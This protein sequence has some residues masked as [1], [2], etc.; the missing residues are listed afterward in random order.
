MCCRNGRQ[1]RHHQPLVLT[2]GQFA[3]KKYQERHQQQG[4][5]SG[6]ME[7]GL[8]RRSS[9]P[10][11]ILGRDAN[12]EILEK[13]GIAPPSYD[14]V[15]GGQLPKSSYDEKRAT[16]SSDNGDSDD[17]SSLLSAEEDKESA[18]IIAAS[19]TFVK[20]WR[21]NRGLVLEEPGPE[22]EAGL[23]RWQQRR[24]E[25]AVRKAERAARRAD[26][27]AMGC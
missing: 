21:A 24:A 9:P 1:R 19:E 20:D 4:L 11:E 27:V 16:P 12:E 22:P 8:Q 14:A 5:P 6:L 18:E 10:P 26:R 25:R 3:Y 7:H 23:N 13:T 17:G 2:L 15:V